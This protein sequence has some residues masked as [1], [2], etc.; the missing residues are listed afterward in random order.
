[1]AS[2][3]GKLERGAQKADWLTVGMKNMLKK[4]LSR[5]KGQGLMDQLV[6]TKER[7]IEG[8]R[9]KMRRHNTRWTKI[10]SAHAKNMQ[11]FRGALDNKQKWKIEAG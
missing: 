6:N 2:E 9:K 5:E 1:M 10:N 4:S 3:I 7:L 8:K 11:Q